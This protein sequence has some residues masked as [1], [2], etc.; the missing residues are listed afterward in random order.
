[1]GSWG[2]RAR[3]LCRLAQ[4]SATGNCQ[5]APSL[6][7][8]GRSDPAFIDLK[9]DAV[10]AQVLGDGEAFEVI[11]HD[12]A[13]KTHLSCFAKGFFLGETQIGPSRSICACL[14]SG[15]KSLAR[16]GR[17]LTAREGEKAEKRK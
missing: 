17:G 3:G 10:L 2:A 1:M 13:A 4:A 16:S 9:I 8:F 11:T 15:L 7:N 6:E 5:P 12:P 14:L